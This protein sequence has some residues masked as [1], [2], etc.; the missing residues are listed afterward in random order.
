MHQDLDA[1]VRR[2]AQLHEEYQRE[3]AL[4]AAAQQQQQQQPP[5]A[6]HQQ[7]PALATPDAPPAWHGPAQPHTQQHHQSQPLVGQSDETGEGIRAPLLSC[8][9]Y[10]T[11]LRSAKSLR[12][13]ISLLSALPCAAC[14]TQI[15]VLQWQTRPVSLGMHLVIK[16]LLGPKYSNSSIAADRS[17]RPPAEASSST[18]NRRSHRISSSIPEGQTGACLTRA[19]TGRVT[20]VMLLMRGCQSTI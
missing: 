19:S 6:S 17:A 5:L 8:G 9:D 10:V 11:Q 1:H 13:S 16:G 4:I 2:A 7:Q 15:Q 18:R 12:L 20:P 14:Y 3:L